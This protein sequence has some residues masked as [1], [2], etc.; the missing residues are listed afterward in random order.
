MTFHFR[1]VLRDNINEITRRVTNNK[2]NLR[3]V[4]I[5]T[6]YM[7]LTFF[8]FVLSKR[9]IFLFVIINV[10]KCGT[11]NASIRTLQMTRNIYFYFF[12]IGRFTTSQYTR[13]LIRTWRFVFCYLR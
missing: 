4:Y 1:R 8:F 6:I 13:T 12:E 7:A 5:E 9:V 3:N 11:G 10:N 2:N